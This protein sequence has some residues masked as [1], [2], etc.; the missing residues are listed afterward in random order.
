MKYKRIGIV[1]IRTL[2]N[3]A[4]KVNFLYFFNPRRFLWFIAKNVK[5]KHNTAAN[6]FIGNRIKAAEPDVINAKT[7]T[8]FAISDFLKNRMIPNGIIVFDDYDD[9]DLPG[10]TKAIN[11][12]LGRES[13]SILP[14][15]R[16]YWIKSDNYKW[17]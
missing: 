8:W 13:L 3:I 17:T 1:M 2:F 12:L 7:F 5:P 9:E 11:D 4:F 16:A 10:C 15:K 6:W 14:E